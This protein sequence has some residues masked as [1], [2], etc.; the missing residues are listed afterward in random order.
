[1][2]GQWLSCDPASLGLDLA[3]LRLWSRNSA[4]GKVSALVLQ[5]P[6]IQVYRGPQFQNGSIRPGRERLRAHADPYGFY[7][8]KL[9][10]TEQDV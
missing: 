3:F 9:K 8:P 4:R 7:V 10:T 5:E 2:E 6:E 1:M